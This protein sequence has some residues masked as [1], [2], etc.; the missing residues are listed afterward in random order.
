MAERTAISI[1]SSSRHPLFRRPVK[2]AH[3]SC[4]TSRVT[5]WWI[6]WAVFFLRRERVMDWSRAADFFIHLQQLLTE[7]AEA[8]KGL[9]LTLRLA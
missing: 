1:A 4:S 7:L 2:I 3:N 5:S 9:D 8:M 6:A